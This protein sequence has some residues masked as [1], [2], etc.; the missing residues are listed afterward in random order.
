MSVAHQLP[1]IPPL[2]PLHI[3]EPTS[4]SITSN[5]L[6]SPTPSF[7]TANAS[8]SQLDSPTNLTPVLV[9]PPQA[10]RKSLSA[11]SLV[12]YGLN[13][14]S[15]SPSTTQSR[16]F[17]PN[18]VSTSTYD[19]S[20][21]QW[22]GRR[23]GE[24]AAYE[25]DGHQPSSLVD[26]DPERYEPSSPLL[27]RYRHASLKGQSQRSV[28]R[29]GELPLPSR[30]QTPSHFLNRGVTA[31]SSS[32]HHENRPPLQ[33]VTSLQS[34]RQAA[35][36][37][38]LDSGRMRSGSLGVYTSSPAS[39]MIINT[40]L[41]RSNIPSSKLVV[42][43]A[44]VGT[45]GCGKSTAIQKGLAG[46]DLSAPSSLGPSPSPLR[47]T[48][49]IGRIR[50]AEDLSD[51]L[52]HVIEVDMAPTNVGLPPIPEGDPPI[53]G[54]VICY[55][56]S[57]QSSFQPVENLLSEYS[58]LKL[59]IVV[60][61]C[62]A[63]LDP[64]I[65]PGKV[66]EDL[67]VRYDVGLIE[68]HKTSEHGKVKMRQSF[69]FL[70]KAIFRAR[71]SSKLG[72]LVADYRNPA[73]PDVLN[74]QTP[75]EISRT[76][77][78]TVSSS[79]STIPFGA[80][81]AGELP[82]VLDASS[83]RS[84]MVPSSPTRTAEL[85]QGTDMV[86][87]DRTEILVAKSEKSLLHTSSSDSSSKAEPVVGSSTDAQ[88]SADDKN[89]VRERDPRPAQWATLDELL[90]KLLFL[91]VS[92][93][94]P[95][96]INHFLLTYRRFAAPR[97]V[98]IAM[99]K[100]I[101][102]L[103]DPCGD[104]MFACF[105][106]MRICH[107]LHIWTQ[108]YPS[109]FAVK[110]VEG[111][112]KALVAFIA[113]KTHLIHY[114]SEFIPFL[115]LASTYSD[116]DAAWAL[117]EDDAS[118]DGYSFIEAGLPAANFD[119]ASDDPPQFDPVSPPTS[120]RERKSSLPLPKLLYPGPGLNSNQTD[121]AEPSPKQQIKD[122]VKLAQDVMNSDADEI[123]QEITRQGVKRF[124]EIKPRHWLYYT[125]V[126]GRKT[127]SEPITAF[128]VISNHLGDWVVSLILCHDR[129]KS[130][131]RQIEKFVEIAQR[132]RTLNNYSALRA[133]VA[134]INNATFPGDETMEQFKAKSPEQAKNLQS[135][136]VLL[137]QIRAH[138][139]Y[140]LALRNTKG[141]CIPA[142][143]VHMSDLIRA[144]EGNEDMNPSDS[145]KIHWG[146]FNMMG[147][148]IA[149]TNQCQAQCE[150]A[151]EYS[152][153]DRPNIA[154]LFV[155]RPVMSLEM[156]KSR[157]ASADF[158]FDDSPPRSSLNNQPNVAVLRKLFFW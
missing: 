113:S 65:E 156:Q 86:N 157:I 17:G 79:I 7:A 10:L 106:Q 124:L 104:P 96:F 1:N 21:R 58:A 112:L 13:R 131:A 59:P 129:P 132:L 71:R 136:D 55:D 155:K 101:R 109:D 20:Q 75:W 97:S 90:D 64:Q 31:P 149:S 67:K 69:D 151:P 150:N 74:Q 30:S 46:Y 41:G 26:S 76:A 100:R 88:N 153:P 34:L 84:A 87:D 144:H 147:R 9:S 99:H 94:D 27:E 12:S 98:L 145:T 130:R 93:D 16:V 121:S 137:Q 35:D 126:S 38:T 47:F 44:V 125:F 45:T 39:R 73:S 91:A 56:S 37:P 116:Q 118:D 18:S 2:P 77:T 108:Q 158:N 141:A 146:K 122:L 4:N 32:S 103:D 80:A 148:F 40:H 24:S 123:A 115:E 48:R 15:G 111:A 134:G 53:N 33:S 85:L 68:V 152:F 135:W 6:Q 140:R 22:V 14:T 29:G 54:V 52:L 105:A 50:Q 114:G 19:P 60:L 61:A 95:T 127:D 133:F 138:R 8:P 120:S 66:A 154:E 83:L 89:Q 42:T 63:D 143:E 5:A 23:C 142:L 81:V 107:L 11:D 82:E 78:P 72:D 36:P 3:P 49:R 92:G 25:R 62:K 117:K 102:Q 51:C 43:V 110:G 128:N 57:D 28:I 139:A 119:S 70:L